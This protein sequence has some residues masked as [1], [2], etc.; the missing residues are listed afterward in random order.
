MSYVPF[1]CKKAKQMCPLNREKWTFSQSEIQA[2][3]ITWVYINGMLDGEL[4]NNSVGI[5]KT[6]FNK[7]DIISR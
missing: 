2:W 1:F 7:K 5:S 6:N 4:L 3:V